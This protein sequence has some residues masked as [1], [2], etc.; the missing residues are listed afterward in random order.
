ML[1]KL[2]LVLFLFLGMPFFGFDKV[3]D[4]SFYPSK[5][6]NKGSYIIPAV[7][8]I[9]AGSFIMGSNNGDADEKPVHRVYIQS[10]YIGKYEVTFDEYDKFCED[11]RQRKPN[12]NGWGRGNHPAINVSWDNAKAYTLW[13]SKKTGRTY[14]LPTEAEWEYV[15]R[16]G[17]TTDYFFG[18]NS[19]NL[20]LYAWNDRKSR[21]THIVGEKKPNPWGLYDIYGNVVEW[22]EDWY[23]EDYINTPRDGTSNNDGSQKYKV[24]RGGSWFSND[25]FCRSAR[26]NYNFAYNK[27]SDTGFRLLE[28]IPK[29]QK[30]LNSSF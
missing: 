26:R 6:V 9:K 17:T 28:E 4:N 8:H 15:A 13:L 16:A 10:F 7:I 30:N 24:I 22:C 12:D 11:T 1:Q 3:L 14:R 20:N 21:K 19:N 25:D 29:S 27:N 2:L 23:A 5:S 18:N